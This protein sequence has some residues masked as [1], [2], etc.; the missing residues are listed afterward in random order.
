MTYL[1]MQIMVLQLY[2]SSLCTEV[3]FALTSVLRQ[4]LVSGITE[5]LP[6]AWPRIGPYYI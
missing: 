4:H 1:G 6:A 5:V 3:R 2:S